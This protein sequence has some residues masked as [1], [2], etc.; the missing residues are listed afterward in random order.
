MGGESAGPCAAVA[1]TGAQRPPRAARRGF[2]VRGHLAVRGWG[3]GRAKRTLVP[4]CAAPIGA[5]ASEGVCCRAIGAGGRG[6]DP[7]R[8]HARDTGRV[9][10]RGGGPGAAVGIGGEGHRGRPARLEAR[11]AGQRVTTPPYLS[12]HSERVILWRV[13]FVPEP[14]E[15]RPDRGQVVLERAPLLGARPGQGVVGERVVARQVRVR[16]RRPGQRAGAVAR[17]RQL[18]M[19]FGDFRE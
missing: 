10:H 16:G 15:L 2:R 19:C 11:A 3:A 12:L 1:D 13:R 6:R 9:A 17:L 14:A 5:S 4:D 7:L 18:T 8:I